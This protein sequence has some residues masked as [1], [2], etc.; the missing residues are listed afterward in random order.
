MNARVYCAKSLNF[1][2]VLYVVLILLQLIK[3]QIKKSNEEIWKATAVNVKWKENTADL[4]LDY[5]YYQKAIDKL[6]DP[7]LWKVK[8][9]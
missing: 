4:T 8:T 1:Q 3:G 2:F 5:G 7:E 9:E 6:K